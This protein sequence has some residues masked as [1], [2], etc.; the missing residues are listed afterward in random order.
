[1]ST[2]LPTVRVS[3]GAIRYIIAAATSLALAWATGC[4]EPQEDSATTARE[5]T[6]DTARQ[7]ATSSTR[8][9]LRIGA[10]HVTATLHNNPTARDLASLLPV[11][12]HMGDLFGREK[13]GPL[14]RELADSRPQ[15]TYRIGDIGYWSPSRDI[16]LLYADDANNSIPTPGIIPVATIDSGLDVIASAGADFTMTIERSNDTPS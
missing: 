12:V 14:P 11:T 4:S 5:P 6:M 10:N 3:A 9:V 8:I 2:M 7:P 1:M 13:A 15:F 16:A